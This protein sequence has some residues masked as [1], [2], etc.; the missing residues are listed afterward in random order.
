MNTITTATFKTYQVAF[1]EYH[2]TGLL[3]HYQLLVRREHNVSKA[4]VKVVAVRVLQH[5]D[6]PVKDSAIA[7]ADDF[8]AKSDTVATGATT[9]LKA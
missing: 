5:L 4:V 6:L 9:T 8:K 7:F 1:L 2:E 3:Q